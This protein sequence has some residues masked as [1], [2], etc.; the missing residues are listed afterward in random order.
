[1]QNSLNKQENYQQKK[2]GNLQRKTNTNTQQKQNKQKSSIALAIKELQTK[3]GI[4]HQCQLLTWE[5]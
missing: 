2:M 3:V 5:T 4:N 1:M